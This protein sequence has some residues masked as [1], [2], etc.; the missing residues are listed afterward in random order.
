M[1]TNLLVLLAICSLKVSAQTEIKKTITTKVDEVIVYIEGAQLTHYKQVSIEPGTTELKFTGLSPFIDAKTIKVKAVG[2]ITVLSVNHQLNYLDPVKKTEEITLLGEKIKSMQDLIEIENARLEVLREE[3]DFLT[4]NKKISSSSNELTLSNLKETTEYYSGKISEIKL[5]EI[6]HRKNIENYTT[7]I[8]RFQNQINTIQGTKEFPTGEIAVKVDA[9]TAASVNFTISYMVS[10]AGWY[11]SYDIRVNNINQPVELV[12]KANVHQ[13]TKTDWT[14][15][16]IKFSSNEP[17]QSLVLPEI[18]NYLLAYNMLPPSYNNASGQV[19]G[20][21]TDASYQPLPGVSILIKGT[22]IGTIT[23]ADGNFSITM[24]ANASTLMFSYIGY[25]AQEVPVTSE[26]VNVQLIEDIVG[27]EEVV[28]VG[29]GTSE[30]SNLTGSVSGIDMQSIYGSSAG[31]QIRGISTQARTRPASSSIPLQTVQVKNKT[32]FEF[33]I[34]TPYTILSDN[35]NYTIN[36]CT[37]YLTAYYE[38][39]CIPKITEAAFLLASITDF[40][41]YNLLEGEANIFF[42]NTFIGKSIL[43][44]RY[45]SDTLNISLGRD[46]NIVVKRS[47][48]KD[49]VSRKIMSNK[50]REEKAWSIS[51]KNNKSEAINLRLLDQVPVSLISDIKVDVAEISNEGT[52]TKETGL[53]EWKLSLK[54]F[55]QTEENLRY[56]VEYPKYQTVVVE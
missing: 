1:K 24:P 9:K 38:Y 42:E 26:T 23:D 11:P 17:V 37:N 49:F 46:K 41:Q 19:H 27:L 48:V 34:A 22:T 55:E 53:V 10:N 7:D 43:D 36:M 25:L 13:D 39:K 35:R 40:Q 54:A 5:Q 29:Y 12:Y 2:K 8:N 50:T 32:S 15:V 20:R 14:N 4:T 51:V 31:I 16:K 33:E 47:P 6:K 3:M 18:K 28:V 21:V 44:V 56:T 52:H 45:L 30:N